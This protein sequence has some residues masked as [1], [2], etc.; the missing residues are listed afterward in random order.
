MER[1]E[2]QGATCAGF[3]LVELLLVLGVMAILGGLGMAGI[4]G[5][6]NWLGAQQSR[7]LFTELQNAC[8]IY[9]M[10]HGAWPDAFLNGETELNAEGSGW[11]NQLAPYLESRVADRLLED[12]FGNTRIFLIVDLDGDHWIEREAFAAADPLQL[13]GRLWARVVI[14]SMDNAGALAAVSWSDED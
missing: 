7:S 12:G 5:V 6:H 3:S 4:K 1:W 2:K 11:R 8:R 10:E 13:P 9:R 14:Y